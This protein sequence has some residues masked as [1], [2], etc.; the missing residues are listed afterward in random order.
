MGRCEKIAES[1]TSIC[2][3][4]G[5]GGRWKSTRKQ[6]KRM[7]EAEVSDMVVWKW[8]RSLINLVRMVW[9]QIRSQWWTRSFYNI[10]PK[11]CHGDRMLLI[12]N[13]WWVGI[14]WTKEQEEE[15]SMVRRRPPARLPWSPYGNLKERLKTQMKRQVRR[16]F[17]SKISS[18]GWR[19]GVGNWRRL[20]SDAQVVN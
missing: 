12:N 10:A 16:L 1:Y 7:K 2:G 5:V 11:G 6:K 13:A 4:G 8:I 17:V 9:A 3:R 20:D 19:W 14:S 15:E 18:S